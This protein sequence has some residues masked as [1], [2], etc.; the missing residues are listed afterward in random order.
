MEAKRIIVVGGGPAGMMAAIRAGQLQ[1]DVIL[2][3]KNPILGKKLIL[4]GKGRCN[5]TNLCDL[6]SFLERFSHNGQFLR[7]AFKK[8]FNRDLMKFFEDRGL[9]LKIERQLRVFPVTD[10]SNSILEVLKKGLQGIKI[11]YKSSVK[12]IAVQDGRVKGVML[13]GGEFLSAD[14]V[15]LATGGISYSFT[16]STGEGLEIARKLGHSVVKLRP[17]LVPLDTRQKYPERLEGLSLKN[18]RLKFASLPVKRGQKQIVTEIG[19]L[20][21]TA[22]GISGPLVLTKSCQIVDWLIQDKHVYVEIDLKPA[23]SREQLDARLLREFGLNP[24][25]SFKNTLK[26]LLPLRLID[27]FI[28]IANIAP[29]RKVSQVT[30][31]EREKIVSLLKGLRLDII[32][33]RPIE[34]AMVTCGGVSLKDINPR[35]MESRLMPGLYFAGEIIDVDADTGGFNLQAAFSTGYL[36]GESAASN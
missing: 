9:E 27:C 11:L 23:L 31:L 33:P 22:S 21:F 35:T 2:L 19:E 10:Q 30:K 24:K 17:G 8:F 34:E 26:S 16:G 14:K 36:A 3:E 29:D 12:D 7:D 1:Q 20:L 15:I 5:L 4:S 25:K 18:I 32:K 6:E 13:S 28:D